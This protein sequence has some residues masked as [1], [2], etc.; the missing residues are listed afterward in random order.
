[1]QHMQYLTPCES[2]KLQRWSAGITASVCIVIMQAHLLHQH[3]DSL[4][5]CSNITYGLFTH[6][7]CHM[8]A[9]F[10]IIAAAQLQEPQI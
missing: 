9:V 5:Q 8:D 2:W 4:Q 6:R 1:M 3:F 7:H 10:C